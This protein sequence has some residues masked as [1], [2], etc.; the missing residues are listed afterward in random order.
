LSP[1]FARTN[2]RRAYLLLIAFPFRRALTLASTLKIP[3]ST[4]WDHQETGCLLSD[5]CGG[6]HTS[7]TI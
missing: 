3:W 4:V 7:W 1:E 6:F 2:S 5:I